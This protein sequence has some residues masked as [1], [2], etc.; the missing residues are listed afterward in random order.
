MKHTKADQVSATI[1]TVF[2]VAMGIF[3]EPTYGWPF[4]LL[5]LALAAVGVAVVTGRPQI[6]PPLVVQLIAT[7]LYVAL[8]AFY[9]FSKTG[10]KGVLVFVA[11]AAF[12]AAAWLMADYGRRTRNRTYVYASLLPML[13]AMFTLF[14]AMI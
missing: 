9:I 3:Y 11:A 2:L 13:A 14:Y 4:T 6:K 7:I 1:G 10:L 12:A 5:C 8:F